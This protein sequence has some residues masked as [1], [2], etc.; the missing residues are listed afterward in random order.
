MF[1]FSKLRTKGGWSPCHSSRNGTAPA[2]CGWRPGRHQE[3]TAVLGEALA[4]RWECEMLKLNEP[5]EIIWAKRLLC[6]F[7]VEAK[8]PYCSPFERSLPWLVMDEGTLL[9][10]NSYPWQTQDSTDSTSVHCTCAILVLHVSSSGFKKERY[11]TTWT[12]S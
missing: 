7:G 4:N 10:G 5:Y 3:K 2:A 8:C 6:F 1:R 9:F 12:T 11:R